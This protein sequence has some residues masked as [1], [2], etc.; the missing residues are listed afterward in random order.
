M[1]KRMVYFSKKEEALTKHNYAISKDEKDATFENN[2]HK[3]AQE[4]LQQ[5]KE[6]LPKDI[7]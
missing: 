3:G 4:D 5:I 2:R 7:K 6:S 1:T